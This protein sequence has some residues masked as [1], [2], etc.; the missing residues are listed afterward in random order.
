MRGTYRKTE[1][2]RR[3]CCR[4][5][6]TGMKA[7]Y[8]C[9]TLVGILR[10]EWQNRS[11]PDEEHHHTEYQQQNIMTITIHFHHWLFKKTSNIL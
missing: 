2:W 3:L 9:F 7:M 5:I 4:I 6:Y 1:E 10:E 8:I 11:P